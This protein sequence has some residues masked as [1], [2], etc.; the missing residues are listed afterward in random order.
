MS[1]HGSVTHVIFPTAGWWPTIT[2]HRYECVATMTMHREIS[3]EWTWRRI[4]RGI[5]IPLSRRC[6]CR[7]GGAN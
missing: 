1:L 7:G 3:I 4:R 6:V 5:D 2:Y